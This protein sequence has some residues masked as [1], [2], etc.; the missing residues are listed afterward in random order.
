[1]SFFADALYRCRLAGSLLIGER[2][3]RSCRS[4]Q[5]Y[6]LASVGG[7]IG[8]GKEKAMSILDISRR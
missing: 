8:A 1:M 7:I 6:D 2:L 3:K 4:P 5:P